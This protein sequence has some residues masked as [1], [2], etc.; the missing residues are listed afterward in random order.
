[1]VVDEN[2]PSVL[3]AGDIARNAVAHD[4]GAPREIGSL[5]EG[6][7]VEPDLH[8]WGAD[9]GST[10][11]DVVR[12]HVESGRLVV[13]SDM[14]PWICLFVVSGRLGAA[15]SWAVR[16]WLPVT[17]SGSFVTGARCP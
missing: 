6:A 7:R 14:F 11:T 1:M 3:L 15:V 8:A 9:L 10:V 16:N 17:R 13:D 5:V 4:C 2:D 12:D